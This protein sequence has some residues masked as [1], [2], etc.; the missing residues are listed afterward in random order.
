MT[1]HKLSVSLNDNDAEECEWVNGIA[2]SGMIPA[3][4]LKEALRAYF[5]TTREASNV[6]TTGDVVDAIN[7]GFAMLS[8]RLQNI[9]VAQV[10]RQETPELPPTMTDTPVEWEAID[11]NADTP[12]LKGVREMGKRP[13]MRLHD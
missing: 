13:A 8:D 10:P 6:V 4:V 3:H 1:Q 12:F 7:A 9:T 11:P 2:S 5:G